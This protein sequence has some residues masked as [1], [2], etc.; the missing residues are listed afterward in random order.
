MLQFLLETSDVAVVMHCIKT[1]PCSHTCD[2]RNYEGSFGTLAHNY[3]KRP[4]AQKS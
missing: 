2:K 3:V 4:I 1:P